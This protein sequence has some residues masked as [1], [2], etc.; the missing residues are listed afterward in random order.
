[1]VVSDF[2]SKISLVTK[3]DHFLTISPMCINTLL[4]TYRVLRLYTNNLEAVKIDSEKTDHL[5]AA[6]GHAGRFTTKI[7]GTE[8]GV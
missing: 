3:V 1:M 8:T 4:W 6:H 5:G 2:A 7:V